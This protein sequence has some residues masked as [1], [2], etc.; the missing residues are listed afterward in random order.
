MSVRTEAPRL[1]HSPGPLNRMT[2]FHPLQRWAA[3]CVHGEEVISKNILMGICVQNIL[4]SLPR[5]TE[6]QPMESVLPTDTPPKLQ[7]L[8]SPTWSGRRWGRQ[9]LF[10]FSLTE[11]GKWFAQTWLCYTTLIWMN[12]CISEETRGESSKGG[13][14]QEGEAGCRSD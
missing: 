9:N 12:L 10:C 3:V 4:C 1:L 14:G 2:C 11:W 13:R 7:S 8:T 6:H 5:L